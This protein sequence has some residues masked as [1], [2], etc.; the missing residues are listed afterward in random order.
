M[1]ESRKVFCT[2]T[3]KNRNGEVISCRRIIAEIS[4]ANDVR[5]EIKCGSCGTMN[6]IEA[7]PKQERIQTLDLGR[8]TIQKI[9]V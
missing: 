5:I 2:G 6:I 4:H 9:S 3:R 1:A 8:Y 7:K